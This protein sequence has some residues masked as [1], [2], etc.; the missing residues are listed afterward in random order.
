M[1]GFVI[2]LHVVACLLL[3]LI[4]L[5][6]TGKGAEMGAVFGPSSSSVFGPTGPATIL[7]KITIGAA[8][9]FMLTSL[10]LT[11]SFSKPATTTIVPKTKAAPQAPGIPSAPMPGSPA[12]MP[13]Q[14]AEQNKK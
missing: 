11:Y 13:L 5:L 14:P 12:Q 7:T 10:Y 1:T 9:V 6:Q 4:V 8:V 3:V 2:F